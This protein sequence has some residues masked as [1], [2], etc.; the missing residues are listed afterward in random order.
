M[1]SPQELR[2]KTSNAKRVSAIINSYDIEYSSLEMLGGGSFEVH[3]DDLSRLYF[4]LVRDANL[5][6][7]YSK[8]AAP[9]HFMAIRYS[10][11]IKPQY[12]P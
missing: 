10:A 12:H 3:G 6:N 7:Y 9:D 2:I 5:H 11:D 1:S 4:D 8:I